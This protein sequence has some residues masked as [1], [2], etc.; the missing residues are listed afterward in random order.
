MIVRT[1][2]LVLRSMDYGETSRIVTLYTRSHGKLAVLAKGA[3]RPKSKFGS[4][5]QPMSYVQVVFYYKAT[6][7]LQTLSESSHVTPFPDITR[8]LTKISVG[9]RI[10]ELMGALM[11]DQEANRQA[12]NVL[13]QVLAALNDAPARAE[14]LLPY[15]QLRMAAELGFAPAFERGDVQALEDRG[16]LL[17]LEEGYILPPD[18]LADGIRSSRSVLRAFAI[19]ARATMDV[20]LRMET[21]PDLRRSLLVLTD[22]YLRYHVDGLPPLRAEQVASQMENGG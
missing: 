5:L 16:G 9:L 12:F 6:R 11:Q 18:T 15:F 17:T 8:D 1:E 10:V 7:D 2:A 14:N 19:C 13:L 20:V 21:T 3:R 4:S 22:A